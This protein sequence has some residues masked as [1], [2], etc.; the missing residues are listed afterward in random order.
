MD[1]PPILAASELCSIA[2]LTD[3]VLIVARTNQTDR[4]ALA[5]AVDRLRRVR[6]PILGLVLNGAPVGRGYRTYGGYY[7]RYYAYQEY[8]KSA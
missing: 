4:N 5:H 6:A 1:T 7:Y 8:L 3:G 2:P